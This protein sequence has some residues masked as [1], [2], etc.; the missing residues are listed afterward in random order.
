MR[1]FSQIGILGLAIALVSDCTG[2]EFAEFTSA[3]GKFKAMMP[4]TPK[5]KTRTVGGI[6]FESYTV[7]QQN[8]AYL[9]AFADLPIPD[10]ESEE[11]TQTRLDGSRDGM[12]QAIGGTLTSSSKITLKGKQPGREILASLPDNK[13]IVRARVYMVGKRLYQVQAIGTKSWVESAE[14]TKFLDSLSLAP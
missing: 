13:G 9:A 7:E 10:G 2:A 12:V 5:E 1:Q 8:G 14:S 3:E 11:Q 6:A 4:G